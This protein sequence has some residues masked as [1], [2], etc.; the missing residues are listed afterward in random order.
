MS[1][2]HTLRKL[3]IGQMQTGRPSRDSWIL[4]SFMFIFG[5]YSLYLGQD[6]NWDLK[7]YHW[8]NPYAF[9]HNRMGFDLAPAQLQTYY[10][11]LL[12]LP[13][14]LFVNWIAYPPFIGFIMGS[15][16]AIGVF[17]LYKIVDVLLPSPYPWRVPY[18][19]LAI[20]IGATGTAAL[21][22]VGATFNDSHLAALVLCS[23]YLAVRA[24]VDTSEEPPWK[25]LALSGFIAGAATG[26]KLPYGV[27]AVAICL[28]FL[29]Y[30]VTLKRNF[31]S[32]FLFGVSVLAGFLVFDGFWIW[33][34]Y[35]TYQNPLFPYFNNVFRSDYAGYI[36]F[37][38]TLPFGPRSL[39]MGLFFPFYVAHKNAML[40]SE[41]P[42][43]DWRL[44]VVMSLTIAAVIVSIRR[45]GCGLSLGPERAL[46]ERRFGWRILLIF[47]FAG[48]A[49]WLGL[50]SAYRYFI[51]IEM[52]TG[53]LIVYYC[54]ILFGKDLLR[55]SAINALAFLIIYT[56]LY[57]E[58]SRMK[59]GEKYFAV[60]A[61]PLPENSLVI[62]STLG[63][64]A[65]LIPFMNADAR[66]VRPVSNFTSPTYEHKVQKAIDE[67]IRS[68]KGPVFLLE[69]RAQ[70]KDAG[71]G[72]LSYYRLRREE[73]ACV[74][75]QSN[76]DPDSIQLCPLEPALSDKKIPERHTVLTGLSFARS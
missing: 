26:L 17:F 18:L 46:Y 66:F 70:E 20:F 24:V 27:Y 1:L 53:P 23:L 69:Y 76:V 47:S 73:Q 60:Q 56:A 52:L 41:V 33:R 11:P 32:A 54:R 9:L 49:L 51:P 31:I 5:C 29:A 64:L 63:P 72:V 13:F 44:A 19:I 71:D 14:Y 43:R 2:P 34:M 3:P 74:V 55:L 30:R 50:Y 16:H 59:F 61:P 25:L 40:V 68:H 37:S 75:I 45:F 22:V 15:V 39:V 48:Y 7:N 21:P 62:I 4:L 12:D 58:W 6:V 36:G 35:R 65:Y 57:P 38:N 10:N 8:Y 42:L 67:V 28:A